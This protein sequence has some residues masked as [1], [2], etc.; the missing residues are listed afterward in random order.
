M[1]RGFPHPVKSKELDEYERIEHLVI[2][3]KAG[4]LQ[5]LTTAPSVGP[6]SQLHSAA[7]L[8]NEP[9][10]DVSIAD[11]L[12]VLLSNPRRSHRRLQSTRNKSSCRRKR[13]KRFQDLI[14]SLEDHLEQNTIP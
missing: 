6:T 9:I 12:W 11:F 1:E 4:R 14:K 5:N 7:L 3:L 2:M 8:K 13:Q 10:T